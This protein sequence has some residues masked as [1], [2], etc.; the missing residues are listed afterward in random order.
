MWNQNPQCLVVAAFETQRY[1]TS[2]PR[3]KAALLSR[4]ASDVAPFRAR[5]WPR[6]HRA[7]DYARWA[8]ATAPYE[9]PT[10][11]LTRLRRKGNSFQHSY[12]SRVRF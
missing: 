5:E 8:S 3:S 6:G 9:V 4:L 11:F 12:V 2:P 10:A 7:T 1:R